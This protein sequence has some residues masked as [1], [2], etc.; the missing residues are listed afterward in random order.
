MQQ[1]IDV[2]VHQYL[3]YSWSA[4]N[5]MNCL[6]VH[7][8]TLNFN[9]VSKTYQLGLM[10]EEYEYRAEIEK[11]VINWNGHQIRLAYRFPY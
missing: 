11:L 7:D 3:P 4:F 6:S 8:F 1:A 9:R 10:F 5:K 2:Y